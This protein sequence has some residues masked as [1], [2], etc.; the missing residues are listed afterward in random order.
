MTYRGVSCE[1]YD[2][3]LYDFGS[4]R[5]GD[6]QFTSG[7]SIVSDRLACRPTAF[8]YGF[9][10]DDVLKFNLVLC[11]NESKASSG[12]FFTREQIAA[13]SNWLVGHR[14]MGWLTIGQADMANY[15]YKCMITDLKLL[16]HGSLP[17]AFS[18]TVVC[19]SPFAYTQEVIKTFTASAS[20]T[21]IVL[22]NKSMCNE[23]YKPKMVIHVSSGNSVSIE[24]MTD[25]STVFALSGLPAGVTQLAVDND[26]QVI[27]DASLAL[28]LV[29]SAMVDDAIIGG[30]PIGIDNVYQYWNR[31]F[32]KLRS[33]ENNIVLR[34]DYTIDFMCIFPVDIGA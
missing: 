12:S 16:T 28:P 7:G 23:F 25:G 27:I 15:R 18:C 11:A 5:Q 22:E 31:H 29:D 8:T 1:T 3:M 24:N 26:L 33:G 32:V 2:L 19:D 9:K 20:G 10:Y 17:W 14:D 30:R 4:T 34:G 21:S 6:V 13:I